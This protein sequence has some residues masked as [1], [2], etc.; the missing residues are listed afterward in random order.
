MQFLYVYSTVSASEFNNRE[1]L[2]R[3]YRV[4]E[5][6]LI[7]YFLSGSHGDL[8]HANHIV[9]VAGEQRLSV[10]RPGDGDTLRWLCVHAGTD[11]FGAKLI[12]DDLSLKIL[13]L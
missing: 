11:D 6:S 13:Q 10:S 1:S 9:C 4:R 2:N 5:L 8:P 3:S 7:V 12:H